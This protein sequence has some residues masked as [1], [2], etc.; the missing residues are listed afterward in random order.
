VDAAQPYLGYLGQHLYAFVFVVAAIDAT[1]VP[2]PGRILLVMAGALSIGSAD[3]AAIVLSTAAGAVG[4]DHVLYALGRLGGPRVHALYGRWTMAGEAW[5]AKAEGYF[6]RF[7]AAAIILGRFAFTIR[8]LAAFLAGA[9]TMSYGRYLTFDAVGALVW[10]AL[11]VL[12]GRVLGSR[13]T[14][15]LERY[16]GAQWLL[17]ALPFAVVGIA[18]FRLWRRGRARA[19]AVTG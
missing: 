15:M 19:A 13:A 6:Q 4:G 7:G 18:A 3:L 5:R 11:L 10:A 14:A 2:F 8:L 1:G 9:G 17:V 12:F 16:P